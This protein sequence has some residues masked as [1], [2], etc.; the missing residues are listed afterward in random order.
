MYAMYCTRLDITFAINTLGKNTSNPVKEHCNAFMRILRYLKDTLDNELHFARYP[1]VMRYLKYTI[2]N[3]LHFARFPLLSKDTVLQLRIQI[4]KIYV[5]Y[6]L[7]HYIRWSHGFLDRKTNLY[8]HSTM[9]WIYR[10]IFCWGEAD[11]LRNILLIMEQIDT[12]FD[13]SDN[14]VAL[15]R[16]K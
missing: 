11:W 9:N 14:Q 16:G 7:E 12:T 8:T 2:D 1:A 13:Y 10:S 3:E 4:E 5:Y 6:C 15:L